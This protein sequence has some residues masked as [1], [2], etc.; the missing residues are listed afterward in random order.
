MR[1]VPKGSKNG[2]YEKDGFCRCVHAS[3]LSGTE[4]GWCCPLSSLSARVPVEGERNGSVPCKKEPERDTVHH[5]L[6][7]SVLGKHGPD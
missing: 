3:A 1:M 6:R 2:S 4:S 5:G 7:Q